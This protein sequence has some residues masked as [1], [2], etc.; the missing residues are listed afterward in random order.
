MTQYPEAILSR[1][2]EI[3]YVNISLVTDYDVGVEGDPKVRPVSNE[4]VIRVFN[5]NILKLRTL[6]AG[7]VKA[8]PEKRS[9][10]CG[11]ALQGARLSA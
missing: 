3:C 8:T 5:Q 10:K 1:E 11:R 9:C 7:M 4:E 6:I 2:L